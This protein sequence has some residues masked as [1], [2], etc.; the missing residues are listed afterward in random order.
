[1]IK[2]VVKRLECWWYGYHMYTKYYHSNGKA[3]YKC[4]RCGHVDKT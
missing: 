2:W 4:V 1:M 3:A